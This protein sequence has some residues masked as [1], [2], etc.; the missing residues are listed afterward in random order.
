MVLS[1]YIL[2][3]KKKACLPNYAQKL[4]LDF[5]LSIDDLKKAHSVA[6]EPYVKA[7]QFKVCS[8]SGTGQITCGLFAK[9]NQKLLNISFGTALIRIHSGNVLNNIILGCENN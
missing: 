4:K 3:I 5:N 8:R 1:N 7:F 9:E 2:L 6:F